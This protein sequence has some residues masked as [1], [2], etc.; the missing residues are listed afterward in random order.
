MI[1]G[2]KNKKTTNRTTW[3]WLLAP[4]RA[5]SRC[6]HDAGQGRSKV[7]TTTPSARAAVAFPPRKINR[8]CGVAVRH[9]RP[10]ASTSF[11]TRTP[12]LCG[13]RHDARARILQGSNTQ[14]QD[15]LTMQ[16]RR[17]TCHLLSTK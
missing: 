2:R 10:C 5:A 1:G 16:Q 8:R 12:L 9:E 13:K 11:N 3:L 4:R 7:N 6:V 14:E 15:S 17:C